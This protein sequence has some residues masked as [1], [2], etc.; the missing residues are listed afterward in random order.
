[1]T[2]LEE[3][4]GDYVLGLLEGD[5]RVQFERALAADATLRAR[6]DALRVRLQALDATADPMPA[7]AAL[8]S[9]I[10]SRL[11]PPAAAVA[12]PARRR[13]SVMQI[14][15]LAASIVVA[16]GLGFVA[17]RMVDTP[18]EQPIMIA[19]L[20]TESAEP[21]VIVE[22]FANNRVHLRPLT[23]LE[24][25]AGKILEVWTKPSEEIGPVSLG[26]FGQVSDIVLP[27][28]SLPTPQ[29]G[30]LYEITLEDA[31]GS[32]TGKPTGP[33]LVKGL[34]RPPV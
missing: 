7:S 2:P 24:V 25:P 20:L 9:R 3:M 29:A 23:I 11:D 19:V 10:E 31:P 13:W 14:T 34:A 22:A 30:Q 32:A 16:A 1:M 8:W 28:A 21:G 17:G 4:A 33:I 15:A 12:K 26:R 27:A 5:E 18:A 6:T